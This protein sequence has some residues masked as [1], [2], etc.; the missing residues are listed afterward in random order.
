M[1]RCV[2]LSKQFGTL[3][4]L[5][6][7]NLDIQPGEVVGLAGRSGAGKT[8]LASL[9][10][11]QSIPSEGELYIQNQQLRWPFR[12]RD[13]GLELIPQQPRLVEHLD[14]TGNIFLGDEIGWPGASG[15]LKMPHRRRMD[16]RVHEIFEQL[17]VRMGSLRQ[18]ASNLSAEQRQLLMI[19]RALVSPAWL[20]VID[21]P[22][23]QLGYAYQQ[24]LLSLI[25][26]WQEK[27]IAVLFSSNN[28]EHLFAV[29]DRMVVLREGR[30]VA[31]FRTDTTTRDEVVAALVG[32][33]DRQ[34]LTPMIWALESYYRARQQAEQLDHQQALLQQNLAVKDSL[35]RQLIEK[36]AV[37]VTALDQ[38][39]LA[40]QDAQR[41]LLTEREQERKALAREL[42]DQVIQD[43]L[44]INYQIEEIETEANTLEHADEL[45]D[46]RTSIR[47][48]VDDLR[49]LCGALRP[50]TID[51]L[52]LGAALQSYTRD[53]S[54]RTGID[55]TL[56]LGT[57]LGR[58]PEVLELSIF[59]IVQESLNNVWKH[60]QA[61][62][63]QI[64]L[65]PTS[66]RA[67]MISIADNGKGL[68]EHFDL[69][70]LASE[71]HYGL[72]G[73]SERVALLEGRLFIQNQPGGG[74]IL[75]VELPHPKVGAQP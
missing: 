52:G 18:Q 6:Q 44:S 55:V 32:T 46:I 15:W 74:V 22:T 27:S 40:L 9:L 26:S 29:S 24:K 71:G 43:L 53:W 31:N 33:T 13:Y 12:A 36:L 47:A 2:N 60:A 39:N 7:I 1:L 41:R 28:L 59:R 50:P 25:R 67:L 45:A 56:D 61:G 49:R 75:Q 19:A 62:H 34:E 10:T 69:A 35:N 4:V 65:K 66:P 70:T 38:A 20:I 14:I 5:S 63:V 16:Q 23:L 30:H 72:L 3:P 57:Q 51:S 48:M 42:H 17:E 8:V 37:Q 68:S 21:E 54:A 64:L 11:G 73:M 58:L